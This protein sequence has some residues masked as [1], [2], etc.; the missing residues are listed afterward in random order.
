MSTFHDQV[1][2]FCSV[3]LLQCAQNSKQV[4]SLV[5]EQ[6]QKWRERVNPFCCSRITACNSCSEAMDQNSSFLLRFCSEDIFYLKS[7][8]LI[9]LLKQ[10]LDSRIHISTSRYQSLQIAS[11]VYKSHAS[12]LFKLSLESNFR[13]LGLSTLC[14]C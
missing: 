10:S 6:M 9:R 12:Q 4:C 11:T 3:H 8:H 2:K 14:H 7:F 13:I 1:N 5:L